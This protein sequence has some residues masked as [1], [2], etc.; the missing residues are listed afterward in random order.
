MS[1]GIEG[2]GDSVFPD[3]GV[4]GQRSLLAL[5][6]SWQGSSAAT[7]TLSP[8]R[9]NQFNVKD[10]SR[11]PFN[12]LTRR[13]GCFTNVSIRHVHLARSGLQTI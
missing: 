2:R 3:A 10:Y 5:P 12:D 6:P 11:R 8:E 9:E 13:M 7:Q 1:N 4:K